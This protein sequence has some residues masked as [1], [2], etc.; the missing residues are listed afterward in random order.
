M[1]LL[2][3]LVGSTR[4][5]RCFGHTGG[6]DLLLW[7][8][9]C[10]SRNRIA[11]RRL[12]RVDFPGLLLLAS[13]LFSLFFENPVFA[14][15]LYVGD[16]FS[17]QTI[18]FTS[19]T[20]NFNA[21][22]IGYNSSDSNN[23][24]NIANT[25]TL[26]TNSGDLIVGF[27]G[28]GNNLVI[29]N[30]ATVESGSSSYGG[31]IG[32]NADSS[33]NSVLVT[34]TG[35]LWSNNGALT[36]GYS[37][38]ATLSVTSGG[39][40]DASGIVIAAR[41]GSVGTVNFGTLG[42]SDT[43][44]TL[45]TPFIDFGSG[46]GTLN[47]NQA[48]TA[49][50]TSTI[51]GYGTLDQIG[52]GT[53]IL[54]ASNTYTG[55]TFIDSGTLLVNGVVIGQGGSA[56]VSSGATLG[57]SGLFAQD[58]TVNGVGG[59]ASSLE[60]F[61]QLTLPDQVSLG[62]VT[63]G[64]TTT[65]TNTE[66]LITSAIGGTINS[67]SATA[68]IG[69]LNGSTLV[70]GNWGATVT[71]LVSGIV[72][73][74]GGG[75]VALQGN[76]TG[77]IS[78]SGGLVKKGAGTLTLLSSN[79][80]T[81][82]TIISSGVLQVGYGVNS[83]S[84]GKGRVVDNGLLILDNSS[85]LN[86]GSGVSGNG[87]IV[88]IGTGTTTLAG[89][90]SYSGA[91]L[92]DGGTL[93]L[94]G[95][96]TG[97]NELK[98][99]IS[100][101]LVSLDILNGSYLNS[102]SGVVGLIAD[103]SNNSVLVTGKR[104]LWSN[105]G[106]LIVGLD[107]SGNS[108]VISNG[109]V[110]ASS[111]YNY[112]GVVGLNADS[113][114]NSV[115][116]MG[117]NSLWNN[118]GDLI[119]GLDGSGNSLVISNGGKVSNAYSQFGAV[120]GLN[121]DSSNNSV[122]VSGPQSLMNNALGIINGSGGSG[123][124]L[125]ISNSGVVASGYGV[126]SSTSL[127]SNNSVLV[128]GS[129]SLWTNI[130][131]LTV[132]AEGNG[133]LTLAN[134]G[135]VVAAFLTIA[136]QSGSSGTLNI[137]RLG[138]NDSAASLT[139]P[140]I[141]FGAGTG[142]LNF[143][144]SGTATISSTIS[145]GIV[146]STRVVPEMTTNGTVYKMI[147]ETQ[148]ADGGTDSVN[149][150]GSGTTILNGNNSYS[151]TTTIN[152]GTLQT[153]STDALGTSTV[154]L[155]GGTL[156]LSTNL[157]ISSLIWNSAGVI[158]LP[159]LG[160]GAFLNLTGALTL[161]GSRTNTF[162]LTGDS[163]GSTPTEFLAWENGSVTTSNFT[164]VGVGRYTLSIT[165]N[166]LW[167]SV[168]PDSLYVGSNNASQTTNFTSGNNIY[169]NTYVGLTTNAS[170]N[171]LIVGGDG[172]ILSNATNLI[173]GYAGSGNSLV[174]SNGGTVSDLNGTIGYTNTSSNNSVLV[175]GSNSLWSNRG[176]LTVGDAGGGSLTAASGGKVIASGGITVAAQ[177]GS[178]GTIVIG[179][180]PSSSGSGTFTTPSITFGLGT[181]MIS[182][183]GTLPG[184]SN[185]IL[186]GT[187]LIVDDPLQ[188]ALT[189]S[190]LNISIPLGGSTNVGNMTYT[191]NR[192]G[193]T[194]Y[195]DSTTN[196]PPLQPVKG[197]KGTWNNLD[198]SSNWQSNNTA[199]GPFTSSNN[200]LFTNASSITVATIGVTANLISENA[201][202]GTMSFKGGTINATA[203]SKSGAG[204]LTVADRL[205]LI[206]SCSVTGSGAVTLSGNLMSGALFQ[207][208][209]GTLTLVAS[210]SYSGGTVLNSGTVVIGNNSSLGSGPLYFE[211]SSTITDI[212][213][214]T[215]QNPTS[216]LGGSSATFN[217]KSRMS[218][219]G[220]VNGTGSLVKA[221]VGSLTLGGTNSY[222]GGTTVTKGVL[223]GTT[224][225]L[226]G[227]LIN[228]A[229]VVFNQTGSGTFTG[230]I[231]GTGKLAV[232]GS[233]SVTLTGSN[234]YDGG[235]MVTLGSLAA[236]S[237]GSGGLTLKAAKGAMASFTDTLNSGSL[238]LEALT[239]NG[240]STIYLENPYS[241]ITST[242]GAI[243]IS[244]TNNFID[245]SGAWTNLGTY[246]L[247]TGTK[248]TGGGFKK[249][250]L[251]GLFIGQG[252]IGLDQSINYNGLNYTFTNSSNAF[253]LMIS[254]TAPAIAVNAESI[255]FPD[256]NPS[257]GAL[258]LEAVPEP[259]ASSLFGLGALLL[260]ITRLLRPFVVIRQ[261]KFNDVAGSTEKTNTSKF[262]LA[263]TFAK[264]EASKMQTIRIC[265]RFRHL[266]HTAWDTMG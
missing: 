214:L 22:Y 52:S 29:S 202:K 108:L 256:D 185:S 25:N 124:I 45:I 225:S 182:T 164:I 157:T 187:P 106:D 152:A 37:G 24:L 135:T 59:L 54:T 226:Q 198:T 23:V 218:V 173:V 147:V 219:V 119:V 142:T 178:S 73:T 204:K 159:N 53:T 209:L 104:S 71:N 259:S 191:F 120:I 5:F 19:G 6:E 263:I 132:G 95:S 183:M 20:N 43:N 133:T 193:S 8:Q 122:M 89:S 161:T 84:L 252:M 111:Q 83:G 240:N 115:L 145:S 78:G 1:H 170:N 223:I 3:H 241:S 134:G 255:I 153:A 68:S 81:G 17:Y 55:S 176:T 165:N 261:V 63:N 189:N 148:L 126:I 167:I 99:G 103:S 247:L 143:N 181:S 250:D 177:S 210:N 110:V 117:T 162:N 234:S 136:S 86:L 233:G 238:D 116:V 242:N 175:T 130:N 87:S 4:C 69:T 186:P 265:A 131:T 253:D 254:A 88:Q 222:S 264:L 146:E 41:A 74:S 30:G 70:L 9:A 114:N 220:A 228:N 212:A 14:Q 62:S 235:T 184:G 248:I 230:N 205:A 237:L 243:T 90:N 138:T 57:G 215:V 67:T 128:S 172:T 213:S 123:N 27:D 137:G 139:T 11:A 125:V 32:L 82:P 15:A 64:T 199:A 102:S 227:Q 208:G 151:G 42:G 58:V 188:I 56:I 121:T 49:I 91:T 154:S 236:S 36:V 16:N 221:G 109:G 216:L 113:T 112:G 35:S 105:N 80:Y 150:L 61:G 266:I 140:T 194:F 28:S 258:S 2:L 38:N 246:P 156:A 211:G 257:A 195:A 149:Q 46:S 171:L 44:I 100:N 180:L 229:T 12:T 217:V 249:L 97:N 200:A 192:S 244:G 260:A 33:N 40:V 98:V 92:I 118:S 179:S 158:A 77:T 251:T 141:N 39:T 197:F 163:L 232:I 206:G 231:S 160:N 75:L 18:N 196:G 21:T 239:L 101:N 203:F 47:F 51:S 72:I 207:S 190:T 10:H 31:V 60:I 155:N 262:R 201:A 107:G 94:T 168:L 48:D 129:G 174:I 7:E 85:S 65:L 93:I 169:S 26:L 96:I 34:G 76:F 144:Q 79:S 127:S 13:A 166:S 50:I 224:T 66:L 245:L